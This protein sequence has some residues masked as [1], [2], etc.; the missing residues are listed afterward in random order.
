M[1]IRY[2]RLDLYSLLLDLWTLA[3]SLYFLALKTG[4]P[5]PSSVTSLVLPTYG[6]FSGSIAIAAANTS[7]SV[8]LCIA[9]GQNMQLYGL[10]QVNVRW[11]C[12]GGAFGHASGRISEVRTRLDS[13]APLPWPLHR[14]PRVNSPQDGHPTTA[15]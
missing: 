11:A 9:D 14:T 8:T 10:A 7:V 5:P 12:R 3:G 13:V 4:A 6:N 2:A 15:P 1:P